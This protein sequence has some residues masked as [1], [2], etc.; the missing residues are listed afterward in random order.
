MFSLIQMKSIA[1]QNK[2]IYC[3]EFRMGISYTMLYVR[4]G[5]YEL[6]SYF[7]LP[8]KLYISP[9]SGLV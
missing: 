1:R 9:Q 6:E 8:P 5:G 7:T 3:I 4:G 2:A